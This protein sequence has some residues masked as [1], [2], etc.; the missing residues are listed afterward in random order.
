MQQ[1][2][3]HSLGLDRDVINKTLNRCS[4]SSLF[5][6][7]KGT[8]TLDHQLEPL[9]RNEQLVETYYI[10]DDNMLCVYC[11]H[12]SAIKKTLHYGQCSHLTVNFMQKW[13]V[14]AD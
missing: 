5:N 1:Q 4:Q 3:S 12:I 8:I 10:H 11:H 6:G 7:K 2:V 13:N 14:G 9:N